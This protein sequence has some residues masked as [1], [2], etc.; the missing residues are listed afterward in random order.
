MAMPIKG[1]KLISFIIILLSVGC[2]DTPKTEAPKKT[3]EKCTPAKLENQK[4]QLEQLSDLIKT[5]TPVLETIT[6]IDPIHVDTMLKRKFDDLLIDLC[7]E[8]MEIKA[9][10]RFA[11]L[12]W[13][14][15]KYHQYL[16][17][18]PAESEV[19]PASFLDKNPKGCSD[20]T[21]HFLLQK[22][23]V[24]KM[25]ISNNGFTQSS[26]YFRESRQAFMG[27][28]LINAFISKVDSVQKQAYEKAVSEE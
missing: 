21:L 16:C 27:E 2:K 3:V 22:N 20:I 4:T 13:Y 7:P 15:V 18:V 6:D 17:C 1:L 5:Q 10:E 25:A 9:F 11:L 23:K 28:Q 12:Y 8:L 24:T 14:N 26:L 19:I